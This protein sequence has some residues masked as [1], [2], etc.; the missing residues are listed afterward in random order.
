MNA[1][2]VQLQAHKFHNCTFHT[3]PAQ[4]KFI[5]SHREKGT[6]TRLSMIYFATGKANEGAQGKDCTRFSVASVKKPL[7]V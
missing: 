7:A 6:E 1:A 3:I 4:L 2:I 5:E